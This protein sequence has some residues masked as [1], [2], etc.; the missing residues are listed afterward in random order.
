MQCSCCR[1]EVKSD[2]H[3]GIDLQHQNK[4]PMKRLK[5]SVG[6]ISHWTN[7]M[8]HI[9]GPPWSQA[10][11]SMRQNYGHIWGLHDA[12]PQDCLCKQCSRSHKILHDLPEN[13]NRVKVCLFL[14]Q[15]AMLNNYNTW[16][17]S[18]YYSQDATEM[19]KKVVPHDDAEFTTIMLHTMSKTWKQQYHLGHKAPPNVEYL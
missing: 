4:F 15:V 16:L 13:T 7:Q 9:D 1:C 14:Q 5:N 17:S 10:Q 11:R 3:H 12:F 8:R 18:L 2:R 6:Q 19:R